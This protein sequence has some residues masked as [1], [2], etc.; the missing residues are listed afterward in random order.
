MF[1]ITLEPTIWCQ[2]HLPGSIDLYECQIPFIKWKYKL[3]IMN[4]VNAV[5]PTLFFYHGKWW[6]FTGMRE[7]SG[8]YPDVELFLFF[9]IYYFQMNGFH[10]HVIQSSLMFQEQDLR[11]CLFCTK[12]KLYRPS[13]N[14]LDFYGRGL[15]I[16]EILY[17]NEIDYKEK[18][19]LTVHPG[20]RKGIK[21]THTYNYFS[22][23]SVMDALKLE[24]K[25]RK[26]S[27]S[28]FI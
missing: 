7:V 22:Q 23:L 24:T 15:N 20:N 4:K 27:P 1:L 2:N 13:Q 17:L 14:C 18:K 9:S 19:I 25:M 16:N 5:D 12:E 10:I 28:R 6:L 11:E 3:T 21:A 8:V 26:R